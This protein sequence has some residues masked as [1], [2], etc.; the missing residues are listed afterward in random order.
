MSADGTVNIDVILN[1]QQPTQTAKD[2]DNLLKDTGKD[3]GK[4]AEKSINESLNKSVDKTKEA[5]KKDG[6]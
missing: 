4:E 2:L 6:L 1:A 5:R 3:T